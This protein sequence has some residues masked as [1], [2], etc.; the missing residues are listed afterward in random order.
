MSGLP[1][2]VIAF[3]T[4][5]KTCD[6]LILPKRW[7]LTAAACQNLMYIGLV[8]DIKNKFIRRRIKDIMHRNSQL[9]DPQITGQMAASFGYALNQKHTNL[10]S[11]I[12]QL[13]KRAFLDVRRLFDIVDVHTTAPLSFFVSSADQ[14]AFL[15]ALCPASGNQA[16]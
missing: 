2:I 12:L 8:T 9:N 4:L 11:Q 10:L 13:C 16:V 7:K 15:P 6:S 5:L 3:L 14:T 1:D